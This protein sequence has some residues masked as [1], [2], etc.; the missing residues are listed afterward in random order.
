MDE[1][2]FSATR[3]FYDRGWRGTNLEPSTSSYRRFPD[4]RPGDLNLNVASS[5]RDGERT[6]Y[7]V[8]DGDIDGLSTFDEVIARG[9]ERRGF[10]V[11]ATVVPTRS[12]VST[13]M[14]PAATLPMA[15]R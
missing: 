1:L 3:F 11:T 2:P 14:M 15:L 12:T 7:E 13:P 4:A 5:D 10:P 9:Y 8:R 6:F